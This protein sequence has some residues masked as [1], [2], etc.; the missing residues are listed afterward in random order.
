MFSLRNWF[1]KASVRKPYVKAGRRQ[2]ER[3]QPLMEALEDRATPA[4]L[5]LTAGGLAVTPAAATDGEINGAIYEQGLTANSTGTGIFP[6]FV[7]IQ[8]NGTEQ[9]YNYDRAGGLSP[10]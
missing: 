7:Q 2:K 8:K 3:F 5:D 4:I 9:G 6:S 1:R 10:Q